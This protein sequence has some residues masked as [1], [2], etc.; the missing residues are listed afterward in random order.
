MIPSNVSVNADALSISNY[1]LGFISPVVSFTV[2]FKIRFDAQAENFKKT[3]Y[4]VFKNI[5]DSISR[6][7]E[8]DD[9]KCPKTRVFTCIRSTKVSL[10]GKTIHFQ[11]NNSTRTI[12]HAT[13]KKSSRS[14][15]IGISSGAN[16]HLNSN[17]FIAVLLYANKFSDFCLRKESSFG[18]DMI[19]FKFVPGLSP[20]TEPRECH[21][22]IHNSS[23]Y[24]PKKMVSMQPII[25]DSIYVLPLNSDA[26]LSSI[27]NCRLED[28]S[29]DKFIIM[30]KVEKNMLEAETNCLIN[31]ICLFGLCIGN[32][33]C[34]L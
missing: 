18:E 4:S 8:T 1:G 23:K 19:T 16:L 33:L 34:K 5:R 6:K 27:K 17:E 13:F 11:F 7:L 20:D 26:V 28:L 10:L 9:K 32:F 21:L 22:D 29:G 14:N 12:Y 25:K 24:V 31:D 30:R 15:E 2:P 3:N